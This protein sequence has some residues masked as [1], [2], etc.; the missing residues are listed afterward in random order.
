M[1]HTPLIP[2]VKDESYIPGLREVTNQTISPYMIPG[3]HS[4]RYSSTNKEKGVNVFSL[5]STHEAMPIAQ[6]ISK[7]NKREL[8]TLR[9]ISAWLI[10]WAVPGISFREVGEILGG[11]DH[12]T[13]INSCKQCE[14]F[15]TTEKLWRERC[16]DLKDAIINAGYVTANK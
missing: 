5:I 10:K 11:R 16:D 12:A 14:A 2:L 6:I 1:T 7:S 9:H 15:Y 8:V 4:Y 3:L 13:A